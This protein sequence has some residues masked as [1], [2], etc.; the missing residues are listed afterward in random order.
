MTASASSG[1][2]PLC[3]VGHSH[4]RDRHRMR[5]VEGQETVWFCPRH[6]LYALVIDTTEADSL[7]RGDNFLLPDGASGTVLREG[8][9]RNGG[10]LI[11]VRPDH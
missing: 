5:P 9:E 3:D 8:D 1:P 10:T 2:N 4:P 7:E 11:Y 6:D